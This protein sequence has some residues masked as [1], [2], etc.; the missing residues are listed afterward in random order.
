M[1]N[2]APRIQYAL[3]ITGEALTLLKLSKIGPAVSDSSTQKTA[4]YSSTSSE[5]TA[6]QPSRR[7]PHGPCNSITQ[8]PLC[9]LFGTTRLQTSRRIFVRPGYIYGS[10]RLCSHTVP[11]MRSHHHN[12]RLSLTMN[13]ELQSDLGHPDSTKKF[14]LLRNG[15]QC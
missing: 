11:V 13:K 14:V 9:L 8:L 12:A 7:S 4:T 5:Y 1:C 3:Q 2:T 15:D 10:S 6:Q